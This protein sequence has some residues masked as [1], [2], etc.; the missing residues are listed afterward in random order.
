MILQKI[1]L[2]L[3]QWEAKTTRLWETATKLVP[4]PL[5]TKRNEESYPARAL[6]DY[7]SKEVSKVFPLN[8]PLTQFIVEL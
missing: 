4:V 7:S 1:H 8:L 6:I 2:T 3:R 5:R